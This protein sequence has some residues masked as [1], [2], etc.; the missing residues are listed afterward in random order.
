[1]NLIRLRNAMH[2]FTSTDI[3]VRDATYRYFYRS[4][5]FVFARI[6]FLFEAI[7]IGLAVLCFVVFVV[8]LLFC[9]YVCASLEM[10]DAC[11]T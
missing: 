7:R 6:V 9:N 10:Q 1:M 2:A 5:I 4:R 8:Y 11:D 3:F